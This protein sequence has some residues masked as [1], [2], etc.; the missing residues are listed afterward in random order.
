MIASVVPAP[1]VPAGIAYTSA[2]SGGVKL[3]ST[4]AARTTL[5]RPCGRSSSPSTATTASASPAGTDSAPVRCRT[6]CPSGTRACCSSVA[7]S[8]ASVPTGPATRIRRDAGSTRTTS[9][10]AASTA[11][12]ASSTSAGSAPYR[13]AS[14]S[15]PI[16]S[17][18][19]SGARRRS[20]TVTSAHSPGSTGPTTSAPGIGARTLPGTRTRGSLSIRSSCRSGR[21]GLGQRD[22]RPIAAPA[23][24]IPATAAAASTPKS[25]Q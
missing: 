18:V 2:S 21:T 13:S 8:S 1:S 14:S 19:G 15:R 22:S 11:D 6:S 9:A 7:N 16:R 12:R 23:M 10:P 4:A 17:P 3:R 24:Q 20:T 5:L 25:S